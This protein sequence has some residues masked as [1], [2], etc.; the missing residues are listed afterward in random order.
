MRL[1]KKRLLCVDD[2]S[3]GAIM[4]SVD[5]RQERS[6]VCSRARLS[7]Q[8]SDDEG[9]AQVF[10]KAAAG[11]MSLLACAS[12]A[13]PLNEPYLGAVLKHGLGHVVFEYVHSCT[14]R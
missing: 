12:P 9:A 3:F 7:C 14:R 11:H 10:Q 2:V 13:A 5:D 8:C 4:K 1:I 6:T